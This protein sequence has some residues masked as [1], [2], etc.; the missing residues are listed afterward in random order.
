MI[1]R[2]K[3]SSKNKTRNRKR[4]EGGKANR[5]NGNKAEDCGIQ[6]RDGAP[7]YVGSTRCT[8]SP[9]SKIP[10]RSEL[11]QER[12][13]TGKRRMHSPTQSPSEIVE[14]K[15]KEGGE[16]EREKLGK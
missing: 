8:A 5:K 4:R 12:G 6:V 13:S 1:P 9:T 16:E 7:E 10:E 3:G 2:K 15:Q 14:E 11:R